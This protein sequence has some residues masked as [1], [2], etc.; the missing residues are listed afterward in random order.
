MTG[1]ELTAV[2]GCPGLAATS[3]TLE[4]VTGSSL[5]LK[6][7]GGE[8]V[9]VT[10]STS[11]K[12][13]RQV[14]GTVSD[15]TDGAQVIVHGTGSDGVIAAQRI[16]IGPLPRVHGQLPPRHRRGRPRGGHP[17]GRPR[18]PARGGIANGTVTDASTGSFTVI[19]PGGFHVPV[20][21]SGS[22]TVYTLATATL[23]QLRTGEFVIAVG[24]AKADGALAAATVEQGADVPHIQHGNGIVP[25][26]WL[27]CSPAAVATAALLSVG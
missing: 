7:P 10:T 17:D 16:S 9:T 6:T 27:G 3:G 22:T 19:M 12:I 23:G 25:Q 21:T 8:P 26:P 24:S 11:I 15:I 18:S 2:S 14:T 13:S 1:G 20:T 4:R 5:V